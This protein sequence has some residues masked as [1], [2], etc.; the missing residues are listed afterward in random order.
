MKR[1]SQTPANKFFW[2]NKRIFDILLSLLLL[3]LLFVIGII[4]I[5]LNRF[6]NPGKLIYIQERMGKNCKA[7]NA[8]KFRTM[9]SIKEIT[10]KYDDPIETDRIT[11]LGKILRKTRIDELPQ[12]LNVLKG[13]MSLI[14]PRPD[15]YLHAL[16]YLDNIEGYRERHTI[17]PGITGLSQ[18]RL[19]YVETLDETLKKTNF[20]NYYI[21]NIGYLIELKIITKTILI[22]IKGLGK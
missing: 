8:I 9:T 22:I 19:G 14:G 16:E 1:S 2:I 20:D 7:F 12:V 17:R 15:Y 21:N 5:L 10:R 3:P 11:P 6:F 4:L 13:E 18:V